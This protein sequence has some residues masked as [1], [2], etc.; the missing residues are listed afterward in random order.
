MKRI[1]QIAHIAALSLLLLAAAMCH[2]QAQSSPSSPSASPTA[3]RQI[4]ELLNQERERAGLKN[5]KW[6]ERVAQAAAQH[7][8]LLAA[9]HQLSHQF[10]GE[11]G[12]PERLGAA[13]ARFTFSGENIA[14]AD[15]PEEVHGALMA[16]PGHRANI[17]STRYNAAGIGVVE[18]Q[19]HLFVAQDFA[20]VVPAYTEA[21]FRQAFI[22]TVNRRRKSKEM[23]RMETR[24]DKHLRGAAC[25]TT[26]DAHLVADTLSGD[27]QV[28]LFT[29]SDP[30]NLP[31]RL[32]IYV[33]DQRLRH[34]DFEV[35]FR[36][37]P[38][39]G[40]GNF[41]VVAAFGA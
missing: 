35:C 16:S 13:G 29:L 6:D 39:H 3:Q 37:D 33:Q 8:K 9:N 26:G 24:E 1:I 21:Q 27:S 19:G 18:S 34:M 2:A 36:P 12:V 20:F 23:F 17:L 5:L 14:T 10:A 25:S 30:L 11:A 40:Y 15:S 7:A 4:F 38:Q 31:D 28:V 32:A 41:W 22:E